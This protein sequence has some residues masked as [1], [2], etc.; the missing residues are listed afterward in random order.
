MFVLHSRIFWHVFGLETHS[1]LH[2]KLIFTSEKEYQLDLPL[3]L[4]ISAL[5]LIGMFAHFGLAL[6]LMII[7]RAV[8]RIIHGF[9]CV[10]ALLNDL[11]LS[12]THFGH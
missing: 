4:Q 2:P 8:A 6:K 7:T 1:K 10:S 9:T 12:G 3:S 11:Q 5:S